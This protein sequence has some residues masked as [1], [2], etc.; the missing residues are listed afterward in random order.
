MACFSFLKYTYKCLIRL[1]F[2]TETDIFLCS[3]DNAVVYAKRPLRNSAA[4]GW[5]RACSLRVVVYK[6]QKYIANLAVWSL[7]NL[8]NFVVGRT[9]HWLFDH[10]TFVGKKTL[11]ATDLPYISVHLSHLVSIVLVCDLGAHFD[12]TVRWLSAYPKFVSYLPWQCR[13]LH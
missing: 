12:R 11:C 10:Y 4:F 6:I 3:K 1:K 9:C 8:N 7:A 5:L 2:V 13:T